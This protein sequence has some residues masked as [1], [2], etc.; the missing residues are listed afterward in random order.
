MYALKCAEAIPYHVKTDG[1]VYRSKVR[2]AP[3]LDWRYCDVHLIRE[4]EP[5]G[6]EAL[7]AAT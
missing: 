6:S 2:R 4:G 3:K 7:D 1:I 5:S